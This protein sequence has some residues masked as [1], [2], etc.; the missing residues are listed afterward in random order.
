MLMD[1]L[2]DK[3]KRVR[4]LVV[5]DVILDRYLEGSTR[6]ISPEAPVPIVRISNDSEKL[7]GAANVA[8]NIRALG[9]TTTLVGIVGGDS[10]GQSLG[11][12]CRKRK[13]D[14]RL[15]ID[16]D[17]TT[18]LKT[19][20]ISQRQQIVR[21]DNE[22]IPS[23]EAREKV[24]RE[25]AGQID[26]CD[27][28]VVSDYAKGSVDKVKEIIA[29]A[30]SKARPI[31]VDPKGKDFS[32]YKGATV[33]KPNL[34][35]FEAVVGPCHD[36]IEIENK[37]LALL[38]ELSVEAVLVTKGGDGMSL[39]QS[40]GHALHSKSKAMEVFDVTG[41]GDT[42]CAILAAVVGAGEK[43]EV[44]TD[45]ANIGAAIAVSKFGTAE[46][47][48]KEIT[49]AAATGREISNS[50]VQSQKEILI[51]VQLSK[52]KGEKIVMTN[53]CFDILHLGH[54]RL[55][56]EAKSLGDRL[57]VAV[58]DDE[59]VRNLKGVPRPINSLSARM[60]VLA[61]LEC[62]DWVVSFSGPNPEPLIEK[63][64]P[65][66]LVKGGDYQIQDVVGSSLV[67]ANGGQVKI[68]R[69]HDGYSTSALL[70]AETKNVDEI[71]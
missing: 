13:I 27:V 56:N 11:D 39:I 58:N 45:I 71:K 66:I 1:H 23:L 35:E 70:N 7:G 19:R 30:V 63:I 25:V 12:L 46:I 34:S 14:L 42:A 47:S 28:V 29:L 8:A 26:R 4:V 59:S 64:I 36:N 55:L 5:G 41:A 51:T 61:A 31:V 38:K 67:E 44:A 52:S 10:F 24:V 50:C 18:T 62:V 6:R 40:A 53:G 54:V 21:V 43:I 60:E 69:F 22:S 65:D 57:I 2:I 33:I 3:L 16:G 37:G 32:K 68:L 17:Y 15:V 49:E 48:I 9:A 20:V